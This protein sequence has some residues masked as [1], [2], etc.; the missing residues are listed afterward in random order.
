MVPMVFCFVFAC[1]S[2]TYLA[3]DLPCQRCYFH[4]DQHWRRILSN[5]SIGL[6]GYIVRA[7]MF[8]GSTR[9]TLKTNPYFCAGCP[10]QRGVKRCSDHSILKCISV[11][12]S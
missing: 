4:G 9:G 10:V 2:E 8:A 3:G 5:L 6:Y 1:T 12:W 11:F 7:C